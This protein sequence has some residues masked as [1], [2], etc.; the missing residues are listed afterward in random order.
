MPICQTKPRAPVADPH[1]EI[2]RL[3]A[4]NAEIT[5][6]LQDAWYMLP[7]IFPSHRHASRYEAIRAALAAG[8]ET[9]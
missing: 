7:P 1:A 8:K 9:R 3:K 5:T 6:A 4:V 2:A